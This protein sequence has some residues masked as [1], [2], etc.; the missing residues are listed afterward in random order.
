MELPFAATPLL[1]ETVY[2]MQA[3]R[4]DLLALREFTVTR[5][6]LLCC[7]AQA[8]PV[9]DRARSLIVQCSDGGT[10]TRRAF[11]PTSN[12]HQ[13][14]RLTAFICQS[15]VVGRQ[16]LVVNLSTSGSVGLSSGG[17]CSHAA[18][19]SCADR[20]NSRAGQRATARS[21]QRRDSFSATLLPRGSWHDTALRRLTQKT[22]RKVCEMARARARRAF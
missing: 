18:R 1:R 2:A 20:T 17:V 3:T 22:E 13:P 15:W 19:A 6:C 5:T 7:A 12:S 11:S 8:V 21:Q 9:R 10:G 4:A 14:K 16:S